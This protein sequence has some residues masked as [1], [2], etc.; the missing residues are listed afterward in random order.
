MASRIAYPLHASVGAIDPQ[1]AQDQYGWAYD[2]LSASGIQDQDTRWSFAATEHG[3]HPL[4]YHG[5]WVFVVYY[6]NRL[7]VVVDPARI[8][9]LRDA[10]PEGTIEVCGRSVN[11]LLWVL[12]DAKTMAREHIQQELGHA[13]KVLHTT[14]VVTPRSTNDVL[15]LLWNP[16]NWPWRT[17]GE[18]V[19][20]VRNGQPVRVG[21]KVQH[22]HLVHIG[23]P[24]YLYRTGTKGR[25]FMASGT[26]V[27]PPYVTS[28]F[29]GEHEQQ[30]S[31]DVM[32]DTVI[33]PSDD[34]LLSMDALNTQIPDA[35][36]VSNFLYSGVVLRGV[37]AE[38][39]QTLW[40]NHIGMMLGVGSE[41]GALPD[42]SAEYF[43]AEGALR[44]LSLN[45]H[46]R[47]GP[48]RDRAIAIHG[49]DCCVCGINFERMYGEIGK[50][51]I[52][53]HHLDPIA[54]A[55]ENRPVDPRNDLVP[56]CPNCHAMLHRGQAK[57][58]TPSE[59]QRML[60]SMSIGNDETR[61]SKPA[62]RNIS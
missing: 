12:L 21:W 4:T 48:A 40:R 39:L 38:Q 24:A 33:D 29:R 5:W 58:L 18:D 32:I 57:P 44:Q 30:T 53:I 54:N 50:G 36:R 14:S 23:M 42:S 60:T 41:L 13:V 45:A 27:S 52:H 31:V 34:L 47:S 15:I 37:A 11:D 19:A 17:F 35:D 22:P 3:L 9:A 46:E 55:S 10:Y 51:F 20:K 28:H 26:V 6:D 59:L 16:D 43:Y 8:D 49:T 61:N 7:G 56:V 62:N 2:V 1:W 25:G